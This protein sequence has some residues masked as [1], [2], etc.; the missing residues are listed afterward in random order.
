[1]RIISL[2]N[3]KGGVGKT[4]TAVNMAIILAKL[5]KQ[6]VL[7]VDNDIQAN[8]TKYFELHD[9]ELP[10]IEDVYRKESVSMKEIIRDTGLVGLRLDI[11]PSNLNMDDAVTGL[12]L[13]DEHEQNTRLKNALKQVED[14]YDFCII[15]NPP[16]IGMNVLN[17]LSCTN[18]VIIPVKIDKNAMD[19][20]Q[21][22]VEISSEM[23][24]YNPDMESMTC[25]VTMF[26]KDMFAGDIVLRKS[27][28]DVFDTRIRYSRKV[29]LAS[30]ET[31]SGLLTYSPRSA[32]CIDY[33]RFVK[34]YLESL[35]ED[36]RK[37]VISHA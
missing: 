14:D 23:S 16:G 28:Y 36:M 33:K 35:P 17:A 18:D 27:P 2:I 21:D 20:M 26:Y 7:I 24:F 19:G 32:A 8:V 10:S 6:R 29:D 31:G 3:L 5:Y 9:Y 15:D 4:T 30:F 1:M 13:D 25:L 34:E 12:L 11:V 22:L 37:G